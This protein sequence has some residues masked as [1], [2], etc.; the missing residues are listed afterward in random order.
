MGGQQV[1]VGEVVVP[2]PRGCQIQSPPRF[3]E[4]VVPL[5]HLPLR[6]RARLV[7]RRHLPVRTRR[8]VK[9]QLTRF[10]GAPAAA[11]TP[12]GQAA[13]PPLEAGEL[14]RV[15]SREEIQATLDPW[16][17]LRGCGFMAEM[18]PYCGTTQ[19]VLKPVRQFVDERDY[20]VKKARGVYLLDGVMCEG[21]ALFGRCDRG[22]LYFWRGEWLEAIP[23][24]A[25]EP[26]LASA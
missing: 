23:S 22:C 2:E 5:S 20:K 9:R 17:Q 16:Q 8:W 11:P 25:T 19:R 3:A 15:R 12:A 6:K 4:G 14:V 10:R 21:T 1:A 24:G 7:L 26:D 18:E 13:A